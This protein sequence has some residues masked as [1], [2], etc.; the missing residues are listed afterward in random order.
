MTRQEIQDIRKQA[1]REAAAALLRTA[2]D[3]TEMSTR[4]KPQRGQLDYAYKL[5]EQLQLKE[6]A[7]LLKGQSGIIKAMT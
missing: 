2:D 3:F 1:F 5:Q 7:Q 6:K 4:I